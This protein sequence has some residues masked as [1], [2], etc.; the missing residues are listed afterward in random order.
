MSV[1]KQNDDHA[2]HV[3]AVKDNAVYKNMYG[4]HK[5][6][7]FHSSI[8]FDVLI[9]FPCDIMHDMCEGIIPVTLQ[10]VS[11]NLIQNCETLAVKFINDTIDNLKLINACNHHS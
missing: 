6:C 3:S 9:A 5:Q 10:R 8:S 7:G 4:V 2:Y 1:F 11:N